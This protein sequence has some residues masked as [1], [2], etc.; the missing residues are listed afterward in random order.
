MKS[1]KPNVTRRLVLAGTLAAF[2]VAGVVGA[3]VERAVSGHAAPPAVTVR[4]DATAAPAAGFASVIKK[5]LP[6]VVSIAT[7]RSVKASS[8]MEESAMSDPFFERFFGRGGAPMPRNRKEKGLGSGV[9]VSSDG[10]ILTN[11]HVVDQATDINVVLLDKREFKAKL[12]GG[13]AK[14]DIAVLKIDATNLPTVTFANSSRVQIGDYALAIGN[15]FGVGQTVT[16]GIVSATGRGNLGIEDYED[17]I[18]TDAAINPGNSGGALVNSQGDLI[19]INTAIISPNSGGNNGVGFAIPSNMAHAIMD[20][21]VTKGKV[22]RAYIGVTLQPVTPALAKVFGLK[23]TTGAL[24]GEVNTDTPAAR[25]GIKSGDVIL[26]MNGEPVYDVGSF[27]NRVAMTVPGSKVTFKVFR[28]GAAKDVTLALGDMPANYGARSAEGREG[29]EEPGSGL[30]DGVSVQP[31]TRGPGVAV[32]AVRDD[33]PAAASGLRKGD[34]ILE[35]NHK[36]VTNAND[37]HTAASAAGQGAV[38]LRVNRNGSTVFV[39]I[40]A[41]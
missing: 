41:R 27:R 19:G 12:I 36:P 22:S 10:Y 13:D 11:N 39:A 14:T 16:M 2:G 9:V 31:Q 35:A 21:I 17:F 7:S 24:V 33:S 15:P 29:G 18:Q 25:A 32:T 4:P 5:D 26:A 1:V 37:L 28:D 3:A 23:E 34:V 38:L 20:Q 6:A 40:E 8:Q 30:L